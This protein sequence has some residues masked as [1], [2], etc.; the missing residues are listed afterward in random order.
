M[1][2]FDL[3]LIDFRQG[4]YFQEKVFEEVKNGSYNAAL[5]LCQHYPVITTGRLAEKNNILANEIYLKEKGID[6][7]QACR[8]GSVTYHGEG[9]LVAYPIINLNYFKKDIH[10]FLRNL[11]EVII[12]TL[13]EFGI[14]GKR[15]QFLTG[16]WVENRK[17]ASIGIAIKKWVTFHGLSINVKKNDLGNF[18]LIRPCGMDVEMTSMESVLGSEINITDVRQA[19]LRAIDKVF[20]GTLY[21]Y[22]SI[23]SKVSA[24][25]SGASPKGIS[26]KS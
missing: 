25:R 21:H 23:E 17:I 14:S 10:W 19:L 3:G 12:S 20:Y 16:V 1:R 5:I 2:I 13:F 22:A 6:V 7:I 8:G 4:F 11:E 15:R 18:S 26:L 24:K 9:Q